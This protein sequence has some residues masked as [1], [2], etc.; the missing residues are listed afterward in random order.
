MSSEDYKSG[1]VHLDLISDRI[2]KE[3]KCDLLL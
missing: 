1:V 3:T 2:L